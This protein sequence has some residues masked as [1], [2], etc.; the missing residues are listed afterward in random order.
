M[1][2]L[3]SAVLQL[4]VS[5]SLCRRSPKWHGAVS[6]LQR[7][8]VGLHPYYHTYWWKAVSG[9]SPLTGTSVW[10]KVRYQTLW[11]RGHLQ[12][13]DLRTESHK[14]LLIG[15]KVDKKTDTQTGRLFHKPTFSFRK[16]STL[17]CIIIQKWIH[18]ISHRVCLIRSFGRAVGHLRTQTAWTRGEHSTARRSRVG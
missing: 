3:C 10:T 18:G 5:G 8:A 13:Y 17:K 16:E 6:D 1:Q 4:K 14:N 12:W 9:A 2:N 7:L 11:S 15:S